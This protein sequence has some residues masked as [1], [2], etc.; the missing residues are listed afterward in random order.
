MLTANQGLRRRF[1]TTITFCSYTPEELWQLTCLMGA[2]NEDLIAADAEAVLRPVFTRYYSQE[3]LTP[4][5]DVIRGIDWLGNGGFVR[6]L[7]EKARD[8]RNNRLDDEDLDALLAADDFDPTD[9]ALLRRFKEL[10]AEDFGE[11]LTSAVADAERGRGITEAS[12]I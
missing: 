4:D 2:Q 12:G 7:V 10:T 1:S 9:A 6:N 5:G 3:S 11:G 8:H